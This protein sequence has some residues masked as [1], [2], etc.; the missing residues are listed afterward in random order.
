MENQVVVE[1][2]V[3]IDRILK[4]ERKYILKLL[5]PIIKSGCNV[6]LIQKSI[7]RDAVNDL[8]LSYLAK[9]GIM[10]IKD[11]ERNDIEFIAN[12]T[13]YFPSSFDLTLPGHDMI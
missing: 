2:Y 4:E 11:I 9:K 1:D 8:S 5:K 6:L 13:I 10:V 12:V 3:Q 7:L